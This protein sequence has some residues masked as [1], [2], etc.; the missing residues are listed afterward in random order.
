MQRA[1]GSTMLDDLVFQRL[2]ENGSPF[3]V[4]LAGTH[5]NDVLVKVNIL[6]SEG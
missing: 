3:F 4:T 2:R 6:D 1:H 5:A